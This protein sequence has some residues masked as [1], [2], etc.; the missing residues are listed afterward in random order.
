[1][2][3]LQVGVFDPATYPGWRPDGPVAILG[4]R[5]VPIEEDDVAL[6]D[7]DWRWSVAFGSNAC[8]DRL[9]DK[10]VAQYGAMLLPARVTGWRVAWE[11]R[12]SPMTGAVPVTLVPVEGHEL[13]TWVLGIHPD[14]VEAMDYSEGRAVGRYHLAEVGPARVG[15]SW[16][17]DPAVAYTAGPK[18]VLLTS[19]DDDKTPL[20]LDEADQAAALARL[21][22]TDRGDAPVVPAGQATTIVPPDVWPTTELVARP[23]GPHHTS[24]EDLP[25]R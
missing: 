9:I 16:L 13:D 18:A 19:P 5:V 11:A 23:D 24:D 8:P 15:E 22:V 20:W 21:E 6:L 17:L 2:E 10:E 7:G 25:R 1:M 12:R 3:P 4:S 14:G